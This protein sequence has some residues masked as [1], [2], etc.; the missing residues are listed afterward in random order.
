MSIRFN[1]QCIVRLLDEMPLSTEDNG[2]ANTGLVP[3]HF[4]YRVRNAVFERIQSVAWKISCGNPKHYQFVTGQGCMDVLSNAEPS[5][6]VIPR[7]QP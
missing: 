7:P 2:G 3:E 1:E 5:F 6:N 4:A